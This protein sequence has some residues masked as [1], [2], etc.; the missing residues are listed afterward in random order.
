MNEQNWEELKRH[1]EKQYEVAN[2]M[3]SPVSNL[4]AHVWK[5][6]KNKMWNIEKKQK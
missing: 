6:V 5:D 4:I 2:K 3:T 1:V